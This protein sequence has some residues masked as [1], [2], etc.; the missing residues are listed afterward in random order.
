MFSVPAYE[1]Y[2]DNCLHFGTCGSEWYWKHLNES[3]TLREW[4]AAHYGVDFS[5]PDFAPMFDATFW[6]PDEWAQIIEGSGAKY[7]VLTSKH[8]EGFTNWPSAT[9]C[10]YIVVDVSFVAVLYSPPPPTFLSPS[11][12]LSLS[13]SIYVSL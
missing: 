3:H 6:N 13:L 10:M 8:H 2:A 12:S 1:E 5:Y 7:A 9:S 4:Q 11:L